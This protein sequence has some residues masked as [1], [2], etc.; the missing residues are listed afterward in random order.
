MGKRSAEVSQAGSLTNAGEESEKR[1]QFH[2]VLEALRSVLQDQFQI[3][4]V[5][6]SA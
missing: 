1:T 5:L 2:G 4:T 3:L 6:E